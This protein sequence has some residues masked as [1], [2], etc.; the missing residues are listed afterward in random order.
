MGMEIGIGVSMLAFAGVGFILYL[1]KLNR[2]AKK[3]QSE[4]DPG[5]LRRWDDN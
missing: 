3:Q 5:K 2:R 1:I 4:V